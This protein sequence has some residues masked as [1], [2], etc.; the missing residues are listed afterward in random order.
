MKRTHPTGTTH[1]HTGG[2]PFRIVVD[3]PVAPSA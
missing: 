3:S 1:R 2:E